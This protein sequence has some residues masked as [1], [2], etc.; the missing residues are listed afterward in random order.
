MRLYEEGGQKQKSDIERIVL[1]GH[2]H[3]MGWYP[4]S[5]TTHNSGLE[6]RSELV[7]VLLEGLAFHGAEV[8]KEHA[9]EN[10]VP[11]GLIDSNFGGNRHGSRSRKL[12]IQKSIKVVT[13]SSVDQETKRSQ[14]DSSHDIVGLVTALNKGLSEHV[15]NSETRQRREGLGEQGLGIQHGIVT[16]PKS[17]HDCIELPY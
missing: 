12:G 13:R 16:S 1:R 9:T 6:I 10:R 3:R 8:P 7:S 5:P 14:T 17:T 15:T 4:H 2:L 11:N